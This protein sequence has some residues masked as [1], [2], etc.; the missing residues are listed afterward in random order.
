MRR[1]NVCLN[2]RS[3]AGLIQLLI[4]YLLIGGE[5]A[6]N[7]E[8]PVQAWVARYGYS[9]LNADDQV[10]KIVT[11]SAGNAV[12]IG[13]T[14]DNATG[15]NMLVVKY[16]SDG[17]ALWTNSYAGLGNGDDVP[18]AVGVDANDNVFVAGYSTGP[19]GSSDLTTIAYSAAGLALW[20]NKYNG[21]L[22]PGAQASTLS[23]DENGNVIVA[24]YVLSFG[25]S[26]DDY[27]AIKYSG[28]GIPL[29]TNKYNGPASGSDRVTAVTVDTNGDVILSGYSA[30]VG[31]ADDYATIK[32]SSAGAGLWTNRY[33][34]PA[35]GSDQPAAVAVG[36]EGNVYVTGSAQNGSYADY[37]T[38]AYSAGGMPL[39]TNRYNGPGNNSDQAR[40][41]AVDWDGNVLVTGSSHGGATYYDYATIKYSSAGTA[42]W[43]N[44]YNSPSTA[45]G[46]YAVGVAVDAT[47][48]V[49]VTGRSTAIPQEDYATIAYS[50][51]GVPLWTNRYNG[52]A[53]YTDQAQAIT[54]DKDGNVLVTGNSRSS[55]SANDPGYDFA[56]IK[57]SGMG[58]GLWTNRHGGVANGDDRATTV[59]VNSAGNV[60][61]GG[62]STVGFNSFDYATVA[63]SRGG[64]PVWTNRY[65]GPGN[66]QDSVTAMAADGSGNV[67]VTGYSVGAGGYRDFATIK[68]SAAGVALWT[69]R[70][71]GPLN[72][73]DQ[74]SA[75]AVDAIGNVFVTGASSGSG[76]TD[77]AT[78]AYSSDGTPL[79]TNR[80]DDPVASDDRP[81]AVAADGNGR[82]FVTGESVAPYAYKDY[83]TIAYSVAGDALWTNRY[84]GLGNGNDSA[85]SLAVDKDGNV[86]VT[87]YS[88]D[89]YTGSRGDYVTIKYSGSGTAMWTNHYHG[90]GGAYGN[91]A[92]T[93]V[94]VDEIG[95]IF[96]TGS[97]VNASGRWDCTTVAFK[98]D[99]TTWWTNRYNGETN[100]DASAYSV[101]VDAEGNIFVAGS[102]GGDIAT[103]KYSNAGMALWTN[104][105]N[106]PVKGNELLTG[107][108]CLAIGLDGAA[109]VTGA[110]DG[111][112][113]AAT[114][115]DYATVKY[116][117]LPEIAL[118]PASLTR[119]AGSTATFEISATGSAPL[120]YQWQRFQTN[121]LNSPYVSGA[122]SNTLAWVNVQLQDAGSFAILVTNAF[123]SVTSSLV[124][125][126]VV[127][128]LPVFLGLP[129]VTDGVFTAT[130][131]N[132]AAASFSVL[133]TTNL[134][135]PL[136]EWTVL[137][138]PAE[139]SPGNFRITD[140][141]STNSPQ[142][143][144]RVHS[145]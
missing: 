131:T 138:S 66:S 116:I 128:P 145:N 62:L 109:Y 52:P 80:Y 79:W 103:I 47:G 41:L 2:E 43:T 28:P 108:L 107:R 82:I 68:Y 76:G 90:P 89:D 36:S 85:S 73:S 64:T 51:A 53:N 6:A 1:V 38:I 32:Y 55:S 48:K 33:N 25:S 49:Y 24:G 58:I 96:V 40:A 97:S 111:D 35:N 5:Q 115:Y 143:F 11:D 91:D 142:K 39:W 18:T 104:R 63:Y 139:Y 125:L 129:T 84:N 94:A 8:T 3:L 34:G 137:G 141:Q 56:T 127:V 119:N 65:N 14:T 122:N 57:Y 31:S 71:R 7:A 69:N 140:T 118:Q 50:S 102:S 86:I 78:I 121:L 10:G 83:V 87:G 130:F 44:R 93:A 123:G 74:A 134:S 81:L 70:Y 29:W 42:L 27:V 135:L 117:S 75:V 16:S 67:I 99:G 77:Y 61:V 22:S 132:T 144:Y 19:S 15:K 88:A 13:S 124:T 92:P 136:Q 59:V 101:A 95:N 110:S 100:G 98:S 60:V 126:A 12:V 37:A 106:G 46:D 4:L 20:T 17:A 54:V 113:S 105:Y 112:Y 26:G 23:V 72:G 30:G 114:M 133:T 45:S 21:F 9:G 120:H